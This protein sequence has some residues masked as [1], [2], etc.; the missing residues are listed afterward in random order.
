MTSD[1]DNEVAIITVETGSSFKWDF[2]RKPCITSAR[3]AKGLLLCVFFL[4]LQRRDTIHYIN[5][6]ATHLS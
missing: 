1:I 6:S 5:P 2:S 4:N 3:I